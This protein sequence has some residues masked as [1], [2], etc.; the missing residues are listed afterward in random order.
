VAAVKTVASTY[1]VL[2]DNALQRGINHAFRNIQAKTEIFVSKEAAEQLYYTERLPETVTGNIRIV[3]IGDCDS[4]P[5]I[6]LH[7][8]STGKI[9]KF[10]ITTTT[11][12]DGQLRTRFK[13][14]R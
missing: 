11:Y 7:V 10:R 3:H 8:S 14:E 2:F 4:C 5:C 9:G 1:L 13:F 6:G 12:A